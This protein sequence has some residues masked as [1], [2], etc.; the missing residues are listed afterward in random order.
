M[1]LQTICIECSITFCSK[2]AMLL[3]HLDMKGIAVSR[4]CLSVWQ[5]KTITCS[6]RNA[7]WR[8]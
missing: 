4:K 6:S 8:F 5:H 2:T 1:E 7:F 3:F